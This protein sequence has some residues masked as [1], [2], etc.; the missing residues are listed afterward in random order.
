MGREDKSSEK[1]LKQIEE[2]KNSQLIVGEEVYVDKMLINSYFNSKP[3]KTVLCKIISIEGDDVTVYYN[4]YGYPPKN[5]KVKKS[6]ITDRYNVLKVGAN[7]FVEKGGRIRPMNYGFHSII[8]SLE[9][10]TPRR[11]DDYIFDGIKCKEVNWNPYVYGENG[12]KLYYQRDFCWTLEDKQNLIESIYNG[13]NLG[14]IL[15][16]K[17]EWSEIERM[18][19]NGETELAFNDIVDGKQRLNAIKEF[20]HD[21]FPDINGNFYSDLSVLAQNKFKNYQML[22]Y[23]EMENG[24]TDEDILFQFLKLNFAGVPQSKEHIE[25]V[26]SLL[27]IVKK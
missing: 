7:P 25:H 4:E 23:A 9:L 15:I 1:K 10:M 17:R 3:G 22:Q 18:R 20:L 24:T 12:E 27:S 2:F 8:H 5:V 14:L 19:K 13:I 11:I 26:K 21:E 16:R 6:D